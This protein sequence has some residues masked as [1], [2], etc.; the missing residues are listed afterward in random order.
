MAKTT[1]RDVTKRHRR[2][3][4]AIGAACEHKVGRLSHKKYGPSVNDILES[5][6]WL[7]A[8]YPRGRT[9]DYVLEEDLLFR[10]LECLAY[11]KKWI[12]YADSFGGRSD[13]YGS[14]LRGPVEEWQVNLTAAGFAALAEIEK[15]PI[16]RAYEKNPPA[17]WQVTLTA[18]A[19]GVSIYALARTYNP[20]TP[21]PTVPS[22][23]IQRPTAS[24]PATNPPTTKASEGSRK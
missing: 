16:R 22:T 3:L 12:R 14:Y 23:S 13:G 5:D 11:D 6:P 19:V 9:E 18:I 24:Q 10:D 4:R 1:A 2:L 8:A 17:W 7:K 20:P 15:S 21:P